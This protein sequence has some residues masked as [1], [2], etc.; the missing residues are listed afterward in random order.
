MGVGS[1]SGDNAL[2]CE[3]DGREGSGAVVMARSNST[4]GSSVGEC[5]QAGVIRFGGDAD[6]C[7]EKRLET[8]ERSD[9]ES[10][11]HAGCGVVSLEANRTVFVAACE[12]TTLGDRAAWETPT[13]CDGAE[14]CTPE[15]TASTCVERAQEGTGCDGVGAGNGTETETEGGAKEDVVAATMLR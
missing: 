7:V 13:N 2:E 6:V 14:V 3:P 4:Q 12:E 11:R 9:T 5:K 10:A 15:D 1:E 8:D